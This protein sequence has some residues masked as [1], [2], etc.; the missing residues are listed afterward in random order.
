[1]SDTSSVVISGTSYNVKDS[2]A[3]SSISSETTRAQEAEQTLTTNLNS[4]ITNRRNGDAAIEALIPTKVSDLADDVFSSWAKATSKPT[5]TASEV[6][7]ISNSVTKLPNPKAL[8]FTGASTGSYDGSNELTINIPSSSGGGDGSLTYGIDLIGSTLSLIEN[9]PNKSVTLPDVPS[10]LSELTDDLGSSPT[11]THSQYLTSYTET[12]PTVPS[13]A[14]ATRKP[15]YT[16]S[17][18]GALPNTTVIPSK[19]SDLTND[20]NFITSTDI[21]SCAT[22]IP[23]HFSAISDFVEY[24]KTNIPSYGVAVFRGQSAIGNALSGHTGTTVGLL[25]YP[26]SMNRIDYLALVAGIYLAIGQINTTDYSVTIQWINVINNA[27]TSSNGLMSSEDKIKLNSITSGADITTVIQTLTSGTEIGSVNGTKLYAPTGGGGDSITVDTALSSTSTNPVQNKAIYTALSNK[28]G[29]SVATTSANGLMS[30]TDKTKLNG[31]ASGA[32]VTI[33]SQALTSGT[34]IGS[35]NGVKLYAPTGGEEGTASS[36]FSNMN[37]VFF[38]DSVGQGQNNN[39]YSFVDVINEKNFFSDVTKNCVSGTTTATLYGRM[40]ESA[41]DLASA[42]IVYCEY[43]YNDI[44]GLSSGTLTLDDI[45]TSVRSAITYLRGINATAQVVWLPIT[46]SRFNK[47]GGES[48]ANYYKAWCDALL[49]IFEELGISVLP[50]YDTLISGHA[51][52]DGKHPNNS[53]HEFIA[54]LIMQN[55]LGYT[56]ISESSSSETGGVTSV[57]G[58]TGAVVIGSATSSANGLMSSTDKTKLDGIAIGAD[59]TTVIQKLTSGAEIGSV[60][61]T[62]LYAPNGGGGT[63]SSVSVSQTLTSGTEI[64]GIIVDGAETK[65]Y[66]PSGGD[67]GSGLSGKKVVFFGDSISYGEGNNGHSFVDI[68]TEMGICASVVKECHTSACVGPYQHYSNGAGYDCIAMIS[69][70]STAISNADIVFVAYGGNDA[71]SVEENLVSLGNYTD[72]STATTVCGYVRRAIENIRTINPKVHIVWLFPELRNY[73]DSTMELMMSDDCLVTTIKAMS[74]VCA[75][76]NVPYMGLYDGL[77]LRVVD[78]GHILNDTA[79]HPTEEGQK[80]IAENVIWNFPYSTLPFR[81]KRVV[82]LNSDGTYDCD[83]RKIYLMVSHQV[84]VE[85]KFRG[86]GILRPCAYTNDGVLFSGTGLDSTS[87]KTEYSLVILPDD[88]ASM[89]VSTSSISTLPWEGSSD[90]GWTTLVEGQEKIRTDPDTSINY[91]LLS[92][93]SDTIGENETWKITWN[94]TA[95][96]FTTRYDSRIGYYFGNPSV[97]GETDDG[98]GATVLVCKRTS[99]ELIIYTSDKAGITVSYKIE[100]QVS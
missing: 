84:D 41:T 22:Y 53:G 48:Y 77:Y 92:N 14:K 11:H 67:R 94:G 40:Q 74:D 56:I 58:Q 81:P 26:D 83:Y 39:N 59:V 49:P 90:D 36:I 10:K 91:V 54:T 2:T 15:T 6:G 80:I 25:K 38:G 7:A 21:E 85:V 60:N 23:T 82:T 86:S 30:S 42:D 50:I 33:V 66:A 44:I 9:E 87:N 35:V 75:D 24:V 16:A 99:S 65:L 45:K 73:A 100:K 46:V 69:Q 12:D 96:T 95:Y 47:A 28:A 18:V 72:L 43:Q 97:F 61:G 63:G 5:Y 29:T 37:V 4:E 71:D 34:E 70:Q 78:G 17:E 3:R 51:S 31:I 93:I 20:S 13:W 76:C 64:G 62:K 8:K 1:M 79:K 88:T 52:S 57:N 27:T 68:I 98:S 89:F 55:P 19:T 32:D